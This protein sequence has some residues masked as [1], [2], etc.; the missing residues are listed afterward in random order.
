[1]LHTLPKRVRARPPVDSDPVCRLGPERGAT[2]GEGRPRSF[3]SGP[4]LSGRSRT[5]AA[6]PGCRRD[7][8][9][10]RCFV[11]GGTCGSPGTPSLTRRYGGLLR[12]C[13]GAELAGRTRLA[14]ET[15]TG[16]DHG[17]DSGRH[18]RVRAHRAQLLPGSHAAWRR[19]RDRRGERPRRRE[20]DGAPAAVR[21]GARA[22]GRGGRR[23]R[24]DDQGGRLRD[25]DARRA[26]PGGAPVGRPRR[27]RR[28]RVDRASSPSARTRRSTSTP[29][30]RR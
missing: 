16:D 5:A 27:R 15:D 30:R 13:V 24:R 28:P 17:E 26:R 18:Q 12:G 19:L 1:M 21:L 2:G 25:Q 22:A 20:H 8:F 6:R 29:A 3:P 23:R 4:L 7:E 11:P 14:A 9:A 10:D